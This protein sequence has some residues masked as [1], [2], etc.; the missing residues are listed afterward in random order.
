MGVGTYR[1]ELWAPDARFR[2]TGVFAEATIPFDARQRLIA[3]ARGDRV[4]TSDQRLVAGMMAMPNP[5]AN[6]RRRDTLASGFVRYEH[7]LEASPVAVY[8]G[9]GSVERFPDYWEL[10]SA[11]MAGMGTIN[12]FSAVKPERTT[13]LDVGAQYVGASVNAWISLYAGRV[14]DFILFRYHE[15]GMTG[16][17]SQVENVDART[18]GGELGLA[19]RASQSWKLQGTLASAWG[20]NATD[21]RALPQTP[22]LEARLSADYSRGAWSFG[23]L[24]RIVAA[25]DRVAI[26]EG[27]VVGRDLARSPGFG[28]LSLNAGYRF[29]YTLRL[30]AG[31]DNLFD[32]ADP[33]RINEPG[34]MVWTKLN[35]TF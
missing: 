33:V 31:I 15:G 25:Q 35:L 32:P 23:S 10:F 4:S 6:E 8:A 3:G 34:R 5:T 20:E 24:W 22:P 16:P 9:V 26:D 14:D 29:G 28:V 27:N 19:W 11:E 18:R 2:T 12:P 17:M 30:T 1:A 13:Q 21:H 7:E